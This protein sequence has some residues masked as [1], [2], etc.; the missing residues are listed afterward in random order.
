MARIGST[1]LHQLIEGNV[2]KI[3]YNIWS[4]ISEMFVQ[5]FASTTPN[6]LLFDT[7]NPTSRPEKK[8]FQRIIVKCVLHLLL[9]QTLNESLQPLPSYNSIH[10]DHLFIFS[11]CLQR[12]FEFAHN[13]NASYELRSQ[14]YKM[15]FMKQM[16][17]LLKQE[18]TS[19]STFLSIYIRLYNDP[20]RIESRSKV[21]EI[22]LP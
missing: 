12:S 1:C 11:D 20:Q 21:S 19:V 7:A 18:T 6:E 8:D 22:L 9:I 3:D 10:S 16:P 13:F 14:L 2:D 15:G 5:L 17:N 4:K